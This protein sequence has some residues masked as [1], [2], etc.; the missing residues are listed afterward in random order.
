MRE[1]FLMI[2]S[3][4]DNENHYYIKD[5]LFTLRGSFF[6]KGKIKVT[7]KALIQSKFFFTL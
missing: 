7:T 5:V 3:K 4:G 1:V 6:E 2:F